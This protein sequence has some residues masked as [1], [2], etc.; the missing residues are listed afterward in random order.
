VVGRRQA[1][2]D[3]VRTRDGIRAHSVD[4]VFTKAVR[5]LRGNAVRHPLLIDAVLGALLAAPAVLAAA[6]SHHPADLPNPG[7]VG[8]GVIAWV[9]VACRRLWPVPV[10][11]VTAVTAVA[12]T[13]L[14]GS[15]QPAL[16]IALVVCVYTVA[17]GLDRRR[18]RLTA[19][20]VALPLYLAATSTSDSSWWAPQN[21]GVLAWIGMAAAV[22][23]AGRSRQA[24]VAEVEQRARSAEQSREEEAHRRV[25]LERVR[26]ARELHDVVT[27]HIA[28]ISVQAGAARH[29]LLQQPQVADVALEHI[30]RASDTVLR[31]LA[32]VV[33][34]LRQVD[35]L[36]DGPVPGLARLLDLL[37]T[38]RTAG[39]EVDHR[40]HGAVRDL[41]AVVD[42]AAYRILQEALTNAQRYGTGSA[43]LTVRYAGDQVTLDVTN[44]IGTPGSP[45]GFGLL[46]MR[47]RAAAAGGTLAAGPEADGRFR[48]RA[49]LPAAG[50]E[51]S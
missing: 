16:M 47:E 9:A 19:A 43:C 26:I 7:G 11:L 51:Q 41:P 5:W 49:V 38:A 30:R 13:L 44:V 28:T 32:S 25:V 3:K 20:A 8:V 21:L 42:L 46:G 18:I 36:D 1:A 17:S 40:E 4:V 22:G 33:G 50:Q 23:D 12:L 15:Q 27:H 48:V 39:L 6:S 14:V 45:G 35:D 29:V 34:V 31:E 24:Y 37:G 10:L 2:Y